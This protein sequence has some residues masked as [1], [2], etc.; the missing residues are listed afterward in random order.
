MDTIDISGL[1]RDALDAS[2]F[3]NGDRLMAD[4]HELRDEVD[5]VVAWARSRCAHALREME[6]VPDWRTRPVSSLPPSCLAVYA[7]RRALLAVLRMLGKDEEA[8]HG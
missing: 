4:R 1:D 6:T 8:R 7:E 5:E 3:D 2:L